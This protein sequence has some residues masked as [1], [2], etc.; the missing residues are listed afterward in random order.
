MKKLLIIQILVLLCGLVTADLCIRHLQD[1]DILMSQ[2]MFQAYA[3]EKLTFQRLIWNIVYERGKLIFCVLLLSFTPLRNK[4][5]VIA[6]TICSFCVGFFTM[7]CICALGFVGVVVALASI[8][9]HGIVYAILFLLFLYGNK[10][11]YHFR[12]NVVKMIPKYLFMILLFFTACVLECVIGVHFVP[13][14]IRL[15]LV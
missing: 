12:P 5:F 6:L 11:R 10:E 13:W 1:A 2:T 8:L 4:L 14:M 7:S 15:S 3:F 9:P